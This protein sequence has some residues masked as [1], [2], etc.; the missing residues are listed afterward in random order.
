MVGKIN[1]SWDFSRDYSYTADLSSGDSV[2]SSFAKKI[3][4]DAYQGNE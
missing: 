3:N 1:L 2:L 4:I